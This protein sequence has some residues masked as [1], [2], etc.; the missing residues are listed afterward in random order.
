MVAR[1]IKDNYPGH[2]IV[3]PTLWQT[4]LIFTCPHAGRD[5][6]RKLLQQALLPLETLRRSEDAYVDQLIPRGA[7]ESV[8]VVTA[9]FPRVFVDLNRSPRE[10]DPLLF[11]GPLDDAAESRSNRVIAGFGVIPKLAADGRQIYPTRLPSTEAKSRLKNCFAPYHKSVSSLIEE[12]KIRFSQVLVVDWHSMP[13]TAGGAA[14]LPD[15]VLGDLFGAACRN[16]DA[17]LWE[18]AFRAEGFDVARNTPYAGGYVASHY[19]N[20]KDGVGVLQIEI[21]RGLYLDENRVARSRHFKGF[22]Q[23]LAKVVDRVL[24][25]HSPA[26]LAAE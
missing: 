17:A 9:R 12:A 20:P 4:P 16:S 13:S 1:I 7:S 15:I 23:Q 19:G 8:P 21:N 14:K 22:A 5:Y 11:Q 24:G 25:F 18:D 3:R 10:L 2:D 6:P 26:A